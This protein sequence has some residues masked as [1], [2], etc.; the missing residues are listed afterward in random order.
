[1]VV[2]YWF[3]PVIHS[4]GNTG[5]GGAMH[6]ALAPVITSGIDLV[7]YG[8]RDLRREAVAAC[9]A[10]PD[11]VVD[12]GCGTGSSTRASADQWPDA[13]VTGLDTSPEMLRKA[14]HIW[15]PYERVGFVQDAAEYLNLRADVITI[16]FLLHEVPS[17]HRSHVLARA[18]D[19]LL[20]GGTCV[21]LD[22]CPTYTPSAAM[23][24]GEPYVDDY[25]R[26]IV[27][28]LNIVFPRVEARELVT[29][30]AV[31]WFCRR[32]VLS[33][34]GCGSPAAPG[35]WPTAA[36]SGSGPRPCPAA[37]GTARSRAGPGRESA[38]ARGRRARPRHH[39]TAGAAPRR[40]AP[41]GSTAPGQ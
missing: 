37:A 35:P 16:M 20:P 11:S 1:M 2:P 40:P 29:G 6:A 41:A 8:G 9:G 22:I 39:R 7:A 32:L 4:M 23:R 19:M 10:Q 27:P 15:K 17:P 31:A 14:R 18:R 33:P 28:E 21:V 36:R 25:L 3:N 26:N 34:P 5:I 38:R 13:T 12:L 30:H 24:S